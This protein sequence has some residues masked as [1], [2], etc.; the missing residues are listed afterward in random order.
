MRSAVMDAHETFFYNF[1]MQGYDLEF[2]YNGKMYYAL[3]EPDHV[4]VCDEHFSKE[5]QTFKN[6]NELIE[7]WII[8]GHKLID[9]ID[10]CENVEAM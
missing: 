3:S 2:S 6:G 7:N 8:D 9:I 1:A 4:A 10:E 5:F